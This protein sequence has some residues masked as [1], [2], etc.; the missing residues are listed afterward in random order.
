MFLAK[1]M[2]VRPYFLEQ[3]AGIFQG[4]SLRGLSGEDLATRL[5]VMNVLA[6][7]NRFPVE[8]IDQEY[9]SQLRTSWERV[10]WLNLVPHFHRESA[11][12][13]QTQDS[14]AELDSE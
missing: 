14:Q 5:Q 13:K 6:Q 7:V 4:Y 1:L 3:V 12:D 10:L 2:Y 8:W 11:F 9:P